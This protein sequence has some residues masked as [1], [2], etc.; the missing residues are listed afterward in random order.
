MTWSER[1]DSFYKLALGASLAFFFCYYAWDVEGANMAAVL[2]G[3]SWV[4]AFFLSRYLKNK[5]S[6]ARG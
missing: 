4:S 2:V 6:S 3:L 1:L 5:E